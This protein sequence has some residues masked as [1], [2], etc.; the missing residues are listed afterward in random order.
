MPPKETF[1]TERLIL[2]RWKD[3]DAESLYEYARD[4]EVGP[5][6]G[7]PAHQSIAESREVIRL[8][9]AGGTL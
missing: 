2:R 7:W 6:A 8:G 5:I 4:P 3:S 9:C 1:Q